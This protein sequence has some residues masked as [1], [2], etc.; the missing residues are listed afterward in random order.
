MLLLIIL[1][2]FKKKKEIKE[3]AIYKA[4]D[5]FSPFITGFFCY[6]I[7]STEFL[8]TLFVTEGGYVHECIK[9]SNWRKVLMLLILLVE[10][11]NFIDISFKFLFYFIYLFNSGLNLKKLDKKLERTLLHAYR[12]VLVHDVNLVKMPIL[13]SGVNILSILLGIYFFLTYN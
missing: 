10:S 7:Y 3:S 4:K 5:L 8:L 11:V 12:K 1:I 9:S 2:D 13:C 6:S